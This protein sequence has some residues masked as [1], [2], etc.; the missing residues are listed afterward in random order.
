MRRRAGSEAGES[1]LLLLRALV[2]SRRLL[3]AERAQ[4]LP[5]VV[6]SGRHDY[7]DASNEPQSFVVDVSNFTS[8]DLSS[9]NGY[10]DVGAGVRLFTLYAA[11]ANAGLTIPGGSCA[12]VG[13]AGW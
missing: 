7:I 2:E 3:S 12:T 6:R 1:L 10:V 5:I 13:V 4:R 11:L 9:A 8:I